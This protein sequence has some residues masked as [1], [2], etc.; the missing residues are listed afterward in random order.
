MDPDMIAQWRFNQLDTNGD[1]RLSFDEMDDVLKAEREKWDT[2]KDGFIDFEEFKEY[3]RARIQQNQ[4]NGQ[5]GLGP[6]GLEEEKPTVYRVG[7]L[8]P[9]LPAWFALYDTDRDGQIGLYEWKAAGQPIDKFI[10]MDRNG[11]GFLTV[12]EVLR[13]TGVAKP[14]DSSSPGSPGAG[15][16][17]AM[18]P[19]GGGRGRGNGAGGANP[20]GGG[21]GGGGRGRGNGAGGAASPWGGGAGGLPGGGGGAN[22]WGGGGGRGGRGGIPGGGAP[23]LPNQ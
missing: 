1:G 23:T 16:P 6:D 4:Q 2:N 20:W 19:G 22:P 8:P 5:G 3:M 15:G 7:K 9:N 14:G 11:D 10:E 21:G 17:V 13:A 18:G 12:E